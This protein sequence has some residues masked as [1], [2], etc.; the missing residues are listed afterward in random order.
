MDP[1]CKFLLASI[2]WKTAKFKTSDFLSSCEKFHDNSTWKSIFYELKGIERHWELPSETYFKAMEDDWHLSREKNVNWVFYGDGD[3]PKS[4]YASAFAPVVFS[5]VGKSLWLKQIGLA[6][7]GSRKISEDSKAFLKSDF[8]EFI[9]AFS[10]YI[11]SG[12][13][14]GV[15]QYVHRLTLQ[16]EK[17]QMAVLPSGLNKIYP[18]S[19]RE[20]SQLVISQGGCLVSPFQYNQQVRKSLFHRRNHLLISL[21]QSLIVVQA[22]RRSGSYLSAILALEEGRN[23]GVIP[24]HPSAPAFTGCND[25]LVDGAFVITGRNDLKLFET[26]MSMP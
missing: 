19:F 6:I 15:D 25:L 18:S 10:G 20:I 4:L 7:V 22:E 8:F 3:Y 14:I 13:A 12:A 9:G 16:N 2:S 21:T 1:L 26:Y 23:I 17:P 11:G 24:G 5:F